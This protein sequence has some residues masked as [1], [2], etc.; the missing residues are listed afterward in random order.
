MNNIYIY[1]VYYLEQKQKG[2]WLLQERIPS[3]HNLLDLGK[4]SLD[5][6]DIM[7]TEVVVL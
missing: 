6:Y 3:F 1:N 5:G 4:Y 2:K 7:A